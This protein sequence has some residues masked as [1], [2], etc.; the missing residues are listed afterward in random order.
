MT[1][2]R[3]LPLLL[4]GL[5][6]PTMA[7]DLGR[8]GPDCLLEEAQ[9]VGILSPGLGPVS[10]IPG[11]FLRRDDLIV[12]R[13]TPW[14]P[15]HWV[16]ILRGAGVAMQ[17]EAA[18][19]GLIPAGLRGIAL[20]IRECACCRAYP[21]LPGAVLCTPE[22]GHFTLLSSRFEIACPAAALRPAILRD[23]WSALRQLHA[24]G[25][26]HGDPTHYNL[27]VGP[28]GPCWIDT[29][30]ML[31]GDMACELDAAVFL[32]HAVAP[33]CPPGEVGD[34]VRFVLEGIAPERQA[35]ALRAVGALL[36]HSAHEG[37]LHRRMLH[38]LK[39]RLNAVELHAQDLRSRWLAL[40]ARHEEVVV[41]GPGDSLQ[42]EL[43]K[44]QALIEQLDGMLK[45]ANADR[46]AQARAIADLEARCG[47]AGRDLAEASEQAATALAQLEAEREA[48]SR[49]GAEL[50]AR[51]RLLSHLDGLLKEA[52]ADRV[53][54]GEVIG[55]LQ[56]RLGELERQAA[57]AVRVP[58][59][60]RQAVESAAA[61][62]AAKEAMS[63][64]RAE[65]VAL[66]EQAGEMAAM[67]DGANRR[68]EAAERE[69]AARQVV[70]DELVRAR[71]A[72]VAALAGRQ[73][74]WYA[75]ILARLRGKP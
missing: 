33:V 24:Q 42:R 17:V 20:G 62:R 72:F 70:I 61:L 54:R 5:P 71:D 52:N 28:D 32:A 31:V 45:A 12:K 23:A 10:A 2:V 53:A 25:I 67:A 57:M 65:R 69:C 48:A 58:E 74:S 14:A 37:H 35:V 7:C 16:R 26:A 66:E 40:P 73:R 19:A 47:Q 64:L 36:V 1:T 29:D 49:Q 60:E 3:Q 39:L 9:I 68:A 59:L 75:G 22:S 15:P 43:D 6:G 34:L 21:R 55:G 46:I 50:E 38:G 30:G 4:R 41:A 63:A 56:A 11:V 13:R 18:P 8:C 27:I 51:S 44:R